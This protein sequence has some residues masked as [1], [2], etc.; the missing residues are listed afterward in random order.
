M[1]N[2]EYRNTSAKFRL[3]SHKL[4]IDVRRH[5]NIPRNERNCTLCNLNDIEDEFLLY[6][7]FVC[8]LLH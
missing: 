3:S 5:N 4:N 8:F 7:Y 1:E 2:T 6:I